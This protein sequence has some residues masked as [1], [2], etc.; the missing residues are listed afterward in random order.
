MAMS[1]HVIYFYLNVP[2]TTTATFKPTLLWST[3]TWKPFSTPPT[4]KPVTWW[5]PS[6]TS[7]T[8]YKPSWWSTTSPRPTA[9]WPKPTAS[10]GGSW[11]QWTNPTTT[12]RPTE[13]SDDEGKLSYLAEY[14]GT[15]RSIFFKYC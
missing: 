3:T 11:V 5:S 14:I 4:Q 6:S 7:S 1:F 12:K 9:S 10:P 2:A 8:T 15:M 13:S